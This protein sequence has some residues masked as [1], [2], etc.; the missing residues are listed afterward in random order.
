MSYSVA[1]RMIVLVVLALCAGLV[2]AAAHQPHFPGGTFYGWPPDYNPY[3]YPW[4]N[5]D[6]DAIDDINCVEGSYSVRAAGYRVIEAIRCKMRL[7]FIY[8]AVRD[9]K[10]F[11]V[12]VS[13]VTA[14]IIAVEPAD[15]AIRD[16]PVRRSRKHRRKKK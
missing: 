3:G 4:P 5:P 10:R 8:L 12:H 2:P 13:P 7:P 9:G 16:K 6:G 1:M 14:E 11:K 15:G